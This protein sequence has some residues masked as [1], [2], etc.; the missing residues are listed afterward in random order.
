MIDSHRVAGYPPQCSG[1]EVLGAYRQRQHHYQPGRTALPESWGDGA[2]PQ[3]VHQPQP[4]P[5]RARFQALGRLVRR[6]S[7]CNC[8]SAYWSHSLAA[9]SVMHTMF[10]G[11]TLAYS[12][13]PTVL[14]KVSICA[15]KIAPT[16][17]PVGVAPVHIH[18]ITA[19]PKVAQSI[20]AGVPIWR[21]RVATDSLS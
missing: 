21:R 19:G 8:S 7:K 3:G 4:R 2:Q 9:P 6:I 18:E 20:P 16:T 1:E 17:R 13:V 15:L 5:R 11:I 10:S 14:S 12:G